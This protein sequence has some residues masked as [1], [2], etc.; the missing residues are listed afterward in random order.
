MTAAVELAGG[1]PDREFHVDRAALWQALIGLVRTSALYTKIGEEAGRVG[2][3]GA[4]FRAAQNAWIRSVIDVAMLLY[5]EPGMDRVMTGEGEALV[6]VLFAVRSDAAS[7]K[8][9]A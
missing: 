1:Q 2:A 6:D 7:I 5:P 8:A 4:V 9:A 3:P